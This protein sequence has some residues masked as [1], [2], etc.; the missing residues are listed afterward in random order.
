MRGRR[1]WSALLGALLAAFAAVPALSAEPLPRLVL[2]LD[3]SGSM[4][5]RVD[6]RP[7]IEI[8]NEVVREL[9]A[10]WDPRIELGLTAY[11]HRREA[12]CHDIESLIPIGPPDPPAFLAAVDSIRPT[13]K[14]PIGDALEQAATQLDYRERAATVILV[15]D[16]K[17]T[18]GVDACALARRLDARGIDFTAHVIGFDVTEEEREQL[19][20]LA[21]AT[22]GLFLTARDTKS[23]RD[24]LGAAVRAATQ[25]VEPGVWIAAGL[26]AEREPIRDEIAWA[27]HRVDAN[28]VV[29]GEA[30]LVANRPTLLV[31]LPDGRYR[32]SAHYAGLSGSIEIEADEQARAR[33]IVG[34]GGSRLELSSVVPDGE[35]SAVSW[36]LREGAADGPV[37]ERATGASHVTVLPAG[38]YHVHAKLAGSRVDRAV[39]LN[40]GQTLKQRFRFGSGRVVLRAA[41]AEGE[42]PIE[43]PIDWEIRQLDA[44]DD[45]P[46][47][48]E[49]GSSCLARLEQGRY[50][51]SA[52]YGETTVSE[53]LD[54]PAGTTRTHTMKLG[55]GVL[56]VF[57]VLPA[58][59]GAIHD[60][61][62]WEVSSADDAPAE[63]A[64]AREESASHSFVLPSGH[65]RISG[66]LAERFG[67]G[68][69]ELRPGDSTSLSVTLR[70]TAAPAARGR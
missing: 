18:C 16:G 32:V 3:G 47:L 42:P 13:G 26:A 23:L 12:D 30:V 43:E 55:A 63:P 22:G 46:V 8:A 68:E 9:L 15:S 39:V 21:T 56:R 38:R 4:W 58:P 37:I 66:R 1:R 64:I 67:A 36:V 14:T 44:D 41:L 65:Y 62:S 10:S 48:T 17:E 50:R 24:A 40:P 19:Q 70:P 53:E 29:S 11:G 57:G 33:Y 69:I 31:S 7:K 45:A 49:R 35:S 5:G 54:V 59:G 2:V 52:S 61:I 51:V 25:H 60:P 20:C 27:I 34:L 6:G 28:R